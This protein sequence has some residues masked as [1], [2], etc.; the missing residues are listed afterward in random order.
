MPIKLINV[1]SI[2]GVTSFETQKSPK[3]GLVGFQIIEEQ[4][5][6]QIYVRLRML[7]I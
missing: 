6:L 5:L 4:R 3:M 1:T 2:E 7:R